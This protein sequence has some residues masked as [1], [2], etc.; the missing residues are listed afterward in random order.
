[1]DAADLLDKR[2]LSALVAPLRSAQGKGTSPR[3]G[4]NA[5]EKQTV[6]S[7]PGKSKGEGKDQSKG[8]EKT[9][10][11]T[12]ARAREARHPLLQAAVEVRKK[13]REISNT[14]MSSLRIRNSWLPAAATCLL[15]II[16]V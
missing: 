16:Q 5:M 14:Q 1:M 4:Q 12:R 10:G 3:G 7:V 15:C 2:I 9:S 13:K 11:Q 8:K 6:P